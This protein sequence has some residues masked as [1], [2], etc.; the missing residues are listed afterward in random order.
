M[1]FKTKFAVILPTT[2]HSFINCQSIAPV[3]SKC[4]SKIT[5][6]TVFKTFEYSELGKY[7]F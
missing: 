5:N 3:L 1:L 4:Q 2:H 7:H 6:R